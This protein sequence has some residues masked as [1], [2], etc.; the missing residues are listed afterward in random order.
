MHLRISLV[1]LL[2]V[3]STAGAQAPVV[4]VLIRGGTLVD[5][6]GAAR[7]KADVGVRGD[8]I[9]FI[10]D[11]ARGGVK[12][13]RTIDATN[14]V[15]A[16]GFIDP[17]SHTQGDLSS[18]NEERRVN[19][20]YLMQGVTT[21]VTNND[22]GGPTEIGKTLDAWAKNGI[23]TNALLFVPQGSV[24]GA[25]LGMSDA[26]PTAA[27]LDAMRAI[28]ARGMHDGAF[29]LSTGL[30]YAPG[31]YSSTEEV[32]ELAKVAAASGGIYDSH[33]RDESSYTIGLVG[34]VN[35]VLRIAREANIP[36][37][38]SHIKALGADVWG[39][40]DTIIKLVRQ[41]QAQ[42]LRVT[43]DQYPYTASGTSVGASLLPRWAEVGGRDSLRA[44]TADSATR[45]R[46]VGEM[47]ENMRRRGGASTLL[48][49]GGRDPS[50]RGKTLEQVAQSR[51][52]S[53]IDAA[54]DIILAGDASVA[55]FNMRD[56]DIERFM[57]EPW[58]AT[59]SDGSDGHPRKYGTFPRLFATYVREKHVL[60]LEEA[61][62]RSSARTA[63]TLGIRDRGMIMEGLAAD[64]AV[65]DPATI[66]DRSTYE[67]PT[68][69]A[70]G[71]KYVL[72]NGVLAVDGGRATG[73]LAGHAL[74]KPGK[75][76]ASS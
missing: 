10:G 32:I 54:I 33:M 51:G 27:Q 57:K 24:R 50:I 30:Y 12:A 5:G 65:F 55:S 37:H 6:T 59:G 14:L 58:V 22:G 71:V 64:I 18:A 70:E 19:A 28:V 16:P 36:V 15:V 52:K 11:A 40:S 25:V 29:G 63:R 38:I 67:Q 62:Q 4:D 17:H 43:A 41:A 31:S 66:V 7:R 73:K 34:A 42:G 20:A 68:R 72:V 76:D 3:T 53:P 69:L 8:R 60:S 74:K 45:A 2:M 39:Q 61:V 47:K 44:R 48:I 56:D 21:V 26:K 75:P 35:E 46:L 49:T 13:A 1:A 9:V 23:G